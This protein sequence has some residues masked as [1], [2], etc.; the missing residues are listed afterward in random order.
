MTRNHQKSSKSLEIK[1]SE[2]SLFPIA[3]NSVKIATEICLTR[4]FFLSTNQISA[5]IFSTLIRAKHSVVLLD[6][7]V[8]RGPL[9]YGPNNDMFCPYNSA[10]QFLGKYLFLSD[11]LKSTKI[12]E[13]LPN[14]ILR[15]RKLSIKLYKVS[16]S[17]LKISF[18]LGKFSTI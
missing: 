5:G 13:R 6:L 11:I 1:K 15:P 10:E 9:S 4:S 12:K 14:R 16:L 2:I 8:I 18:L 3:Y 17:F 7:G